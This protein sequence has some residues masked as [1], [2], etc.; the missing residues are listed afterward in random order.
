MR[1]TSLR[2]D[3]ILWKL[4][5]T[6]EPWSSNGCYIPGYD[7][8]RELRRWWMDFGKCTTD[9]SSRGSSA[10]GYSW[11][12]AGPEPAG[13][14]RRVEFGSCTACCSTAE[15]GSELEFGTSDCAG[16]VRRRGLDFGERTAS[17]SFAC[18]SALGYSGI[19]A[20]SEPAGAERWLEFGAGT[21]RCSSTG[22][23]TKLESGTTGCDGCARDGRRGRYRDDA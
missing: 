2:G 10:A 22:P 23:G 6:G 19:F 18:T 14:G 5:K 1:N 21:T 13:A 15:F 16:A 3:Q 9:Y 11:V 17:S 7:S 8:A 20:G 4:R 12:V